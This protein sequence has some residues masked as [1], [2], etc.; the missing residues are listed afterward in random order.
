MEASALRLEATASR[1]EAIALRLEAAASRLEASALR[2]EAISSRLV[3]KPLGS[4]QESPRSRAHRKLLAALGDL[5]AD[6]L[7]RA[8][9]DATAAGVDEEGLA[10]VQAIDVGL[11]N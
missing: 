7:H 3:G 4:S 8:I 1:L 6:A 5:D 10:A 2:L 9:Q 11:L